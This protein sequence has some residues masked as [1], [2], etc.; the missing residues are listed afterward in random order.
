[1]AQRKSDNGKSHEEKLADRLTAD[2]Q[3]RKDRLQRPDP[4][5]AAVMRKVRDTDIEGDN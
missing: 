4:Q 1:M 5:E 2:D 3:K